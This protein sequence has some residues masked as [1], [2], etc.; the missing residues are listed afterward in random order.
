R[1][2]PIAEVA[3]IGRNF[4][5]PLIVDNTAAPALCQPIK[6]GAA[7][8]MLSLTKYVGGHGTSIGGI[9]V[10]GGNFDWEKHANRFPMLTRP[11]RSYHGAVW[12][13]AAKPLGPIAYIL[14]ARV[15][16]LRDIGASM[17]PF[18][19]FMFLQGL[20]TLPLRMR[21]HCRNAETVAGYLAGHPR[22]A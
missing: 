4:G 20:E 5:V 6:H 8:S 1:V 21:E 16:L 11:D 7:I 18:S 9:I 22:I 2:F 17:S 13:E 15:T 12:T 19:A 3:R 14:K 10:D